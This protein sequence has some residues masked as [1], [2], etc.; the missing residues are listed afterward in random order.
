MLSAKY[1]VTIIYT[2]FV[3]FFGGIGVACGLGWGAFELENFATTMLHLHLCSKKKLVHRTLAR[4]M[5][6][7]SGEDFEVGLPSGLDDTHVLI[8]KL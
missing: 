7:R 5:Y 1:E 2:S 6:G 3:D 8:S 4:C